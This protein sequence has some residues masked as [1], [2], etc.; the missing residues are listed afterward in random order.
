MKPKIYY[1]FESSS[2]GIGHSWIKEGTTIDSPTEDYLYCLYESL[3]LTIKN[4]QIIEPEY[5]H[6]VYYQVGLLDNKDLKEH[7]FPAEIS[8]AQM[9]FLQQN[10]L[11]DIK[12]ALHK[13]K[14]IH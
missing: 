11:S 4:N 13:N 14:N 8:K 2:R 10:A 6:N 1:D 7:V 12:A 5:I 3:T 9:L